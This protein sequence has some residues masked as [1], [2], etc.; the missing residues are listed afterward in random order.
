MEH[1]NLFIIGIFTLLVWLILKCYFKRSSLN[2]PGPKGLP[3]V[4][5]AFQLEQP[6][7]ILSYWK[8]KYGDIYK[9]NIF[10]NDV[11]VLNSDDA[12]YECLVTKS[13][14]FAGR[15][16]IWRTQNYFKDNVSIIFANPTSEWMLWKKTSTHGLH[17][18]ADGLQHLEQVSREVI[19]DFLTLLDGKVGCDYDMTED[20]HSSL[21]NILATLVRIV[22][23]PVATNS[24]YTRDNQKY[25]E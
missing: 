16:Q 18:Y 25:L 21:T 12:L 6:H 23:Y 5:N 15:P 8:Q 13:D 7:L 22:K 3:F 19:D 11:V 9:I 4:G 17:T 20:L 24:T 1:L 14:D 10:G 2:L